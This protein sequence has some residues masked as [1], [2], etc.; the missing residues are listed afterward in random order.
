MI[1]ARRTIRP[2]EWAITFAVAVLA[3]LLL[4]AGD[5]VRPVL[6]PGLM[7]G[8][9]AGSAL[10][11]LVRSLT[12]CRESLRAGG[13]YAH[14][15]SAAFG[16]GV[17]LAVVLPGLQLLAGAR[18]SRIESLGFPT[19]DVGP[20]LALAFLLYAMAVGAFYFGE[21]VVGGGEALRERRFRLEGV[22]PLGRTWESRGTYLVLLVIGVLFVLFAGT[23]FEDRGRTVGQGFTQLFGYAAP[24]AIA[25]GVLN[26]HW[27]SRTYVV[28]S[29]VGVGVLLPGG[30]RTPLLIVAAA[31]AM[32]YL[33]SSAAQPIR[34]RQVLAAG[35]AIYMGATMLVALSTY[36]GSRDAAD[37]ASL[38]TNVA[39]AAVNPFSQ[40][41]AQGVD[42]VDGL[43]LA[44][45]VD[46]EYVGASW[47]DPTKVVTGFV[48]RQLWPEKPIW[49]GTTVTQAY[50]NFGA[51]GIF[52]SG[53]GYALIVFGSI[54]AVP[55]LFG[56]LGAFS[57][58]LL[59]RM[60]E[61]SVWSALLV[62]FLMRFFF[63]GDAFD[64]FHVLGLCIVF[65]FARTVRGVLGLLHR[66]P[67]SARRRVA[68]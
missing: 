64:A 2:A 33:R 59:R 55:V 67:E 31:V 27:G 32:R 56:L 17:L 5:R 39:R 15:G 65:V 38:P 18:E 44:T 22:R 14:L 36:R 6:S 53:P 4:A 28:L 51:G 54:A 52:L 11:V 58:S 41:Q 10:F 45:K 9:L 1:R 47:L 26:R 68:G 20:D 46:R 35:L 57:E 21:T 43:I 63:A 24:I 66:P 16:F 19:P 34:W 42:T 30:V 7:A 40:L 49:L 61:P 50:T 29:L 8:V 13:G 60:I 3:G 62:Y 12:I 23:S 25:I 37:A 48:P